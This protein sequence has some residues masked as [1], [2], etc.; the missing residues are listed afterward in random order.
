MEVSVIGSSQQQAA[1]VGARE[2]GFCSWKAQSLKLFGSRNKICFDQNSNSNNGRW[3]KASLRF[4]PKAEQ[5]EPV[6]S[7][8]VSSVLKG[9]SKSV[10]FFFFFFS[11]LFWVVRN[12]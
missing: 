12:F 11:N 7:K 4:T 10:S 3:R 6:R 5:S 9:K 2:L 8:E 1:K